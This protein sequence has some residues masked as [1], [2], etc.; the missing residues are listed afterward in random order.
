MALIAGACSGEKQP[1]QPVVAQAFPEL[2]I[3]VFAAIPSQI[4]VIGTQF[5]MLKNEV[6][7]ISQGRISLS[8]ASDRDTADCLLV[9]AHDA[10]PMIGPVAHLLEGV[11]N[12]L[13]PDEHNAW[14]HS[15][16]L[17]AVV[18][19]ISSNAGLN[20]VP[21]SA[22]GLQCGWTQQSVE[23]VADLAELKMRGAG[24]TGMVLRQLGA[25]I[26][27]MSPREIEPALQS[28]DLNSFE[29]IGPAVDTLVV[30]SSKNMT[31]VAGWNERVSQTLL[32]VRS[33]E[34]QQ[35][36]AVLQL[37]HSVGRSVHLQSSS[38]MYL[39]NARALQSIAKVERCSPD[40]S[41]AVETTCTEI[42]Q[43]FA[44]QDST[45]A[46]AYESYKQWFSTARRW[47]HISE[48]R[49]LETR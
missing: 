29:F 13:T 25:T 34:L 36:D 6:E 12:G 42:L 30:P 44:T 45:F 46:T 16:E 48:Q 26:S 43:E 27:N 40:I 18:D 33:S 9:P 5:D 24:L 35:E 38:Q 2:N 17:G 47:T 4:P 19:S 10:A 22:F 7:A 8:V 11:P 20:I 41:D 39:A 23:S 28:G 49:Y 32:L 21:M 14:L 37:L 15:T 3:S 1:S 31:L